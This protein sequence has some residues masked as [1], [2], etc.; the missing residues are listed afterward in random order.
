MSNLT[1]TPATT[2]VEALQQ[3]WHRV[4]HRPIAPDNDFFDLGGN[5]WLAAELFTQIN[6]TFNAQFPAVTIC[7]SPTIAALAASLEN[8]QPGAPAILLHDGAPQAAP[9]F[10]FHGIG[11]SVVDL[12]PLVRRLQSDQTIYALEAKGNNGKEAPLDRIEAIAQSYVRTIR[13]IQ[14]HG[15]YFLIGYSLGGL[16]ALE[17]VQQLKS[18][19]E[20]IALLV[21]LDSYPDRRYLS[22]PQYAR[23]LLQ[24][25]KSRVKGQDAVGRKYSSNENA[26]RRASL[27]IAIERVKAAH[28][29]A[30]YNYRPRFYDGEV[31]F[32][33]AG[34]PS[35]FPADP[36]PF[37][38]HV[39]PKLEVETVPGNHVALLTTSV[40]QVASLLD[41]Y[42]RNARAHRAPMP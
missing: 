34:V 31:K 14:P 6:Q 13:Q 4:F 11:S 15:P 5:T 26:D 16:I 32:V 12:V 37:W 18:E 24:I 41:K 22:F 1:T 25:A 3:I 9:I 29:R 30:L 28:Y 33:R 42:V 38:S 19:S 7:N 21:M 39:I 17:S 40:D 27:V 23:L 20:E 36:V 10:M 35:H 8:P 2:K